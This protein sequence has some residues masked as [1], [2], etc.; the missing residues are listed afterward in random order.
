MR[1]QPHSIKTST[2]QVFEHQLLRVGTTVDGV[3]FE[4]ADFLAMARFAEGSRAK[5]YKLLHKAVR[6]SHYVGAIQVGRLT[7]EILPKADRERRPDKGLWHDLLLEMLKVC[8]LLKIESHSVAPL[9]LRGN[10][11]LD[12]YFSIFLDEVEQLLRQGLIKAYHHDEANRRYLKGRLLLNRQLRHNTQHPERF[13]TR[14][15]HYDYDHLPNQLLKATLKALGQLLP[16]SELQAKARNLLDRFPPVQS[17]QAS[18]AHFDRIPLDRKTIP[19]QAALQIARLILLNFSPDIRSGTH[20]LLAIVFDMNLLFEEYVYRK[21][22]SLE[23]RDWQVRRQ[24]QRTF[25]KRRRIQPD[26]VIRTGGQTYVLDTKWKV[27]KVTRPSMEDLRQLYV[28]CRYFGARKGVLLY[29]KVYDL[30]D[31]PAT[32][33]AALEGEEEREE[34][35]CQLSFLE[36]VREGRLNREIGGEVKKMLMD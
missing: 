4:E 3:R 30:A 9:R 16:S 15:Q 29:P 33:F 23:S 6:F 14:S 24:L 26:I 34:Y 17:I 22:K 25:W 20:P 21:L 5:Y 32:A 36:L 35:F 2:I 13:F 8:R 28:Y 10:S 12:L 31:Q 7:I 11:I 18:E 27:L 1:G 19:Y